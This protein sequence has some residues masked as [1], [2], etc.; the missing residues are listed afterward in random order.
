MNRQIKILKKAKESLNKLGLTVQKR[1]ADF[2]LT[3]VVNDPLSKGKALTGEKHGLRMYKMDD[4]K[5]TC[6]VT[7]YEIIIMVISDTSK[8]KITKEKLA[9]T[10][11]GA[12]IRENLNRLGKFK[13]F[14][15]EGQ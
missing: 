8:N 4:I 15:T 11:F 1:V 5:L 10:D 7:Y 12:I 6:K 13:G 9:K 14:K 2:L 3:E